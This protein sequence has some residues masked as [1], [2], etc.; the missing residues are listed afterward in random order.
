[1]ST[2]PTTT[3][4][5]D[6]APL[7]TQAV[8]GLLAPPTYPHRQPNVLGFNFTALTNLGPYDLF[9]TSLDHVTFLA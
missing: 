5:T 9:S 7:D 2:T 6:L 3:T 8:T 4:G 1:M